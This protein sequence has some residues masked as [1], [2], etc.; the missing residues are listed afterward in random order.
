MIMSNNDW[1][2]NDVRYEMINCDIVFIVICV[3]NSIDILK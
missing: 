3:V 2:L 1:K